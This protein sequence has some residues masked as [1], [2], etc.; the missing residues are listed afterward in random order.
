MDPTYEKST[1]LA[2]NILLALKIKETLEKNMRLQERIKDIQ[3][4]K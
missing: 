1:M 3:G 2:S 4:V